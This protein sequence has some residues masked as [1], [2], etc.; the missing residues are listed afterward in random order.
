MD[1]SLK[2]FGFEYTV[3][4]RRYATHIEADAP[5]ELIGELKPQE[6]APPEQVG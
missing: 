1:S 6:S 2:T 5:P 4:G 3:N